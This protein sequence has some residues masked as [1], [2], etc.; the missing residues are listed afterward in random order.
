MIMM[1]FVCLFVVRNSINDALGS[2]GKSLSR[3]AVKGV[4]LGAEE[5]GETLLLSLSSE[6]GS[7]PD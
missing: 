2:G 6:A 3:S 7:I 5:M 1:A 4:V